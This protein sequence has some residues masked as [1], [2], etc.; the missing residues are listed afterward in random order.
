[1]RVESRNRI[2]GNILVMMTVVSLAFVTFGQLQQG[3]GVVPI[4]ISGSAATATSAAQ[5]EPGLTNQ[6]RFDATNAATAARISATNNAGVT[7][8]LNAETSDLATVAETANAVNAA[9][10][11]SAG[12]FTGTGTPGLVGIWAPN[13]GGTVYWSPPSSN[14]PIGSAIFLGADHVLSIGKLQSTNIAGVF[15]NEVNTSGSVTASG[16]SSTSSTWGTVTMPVN[17]NG[18]SYFTNTASYTIWYAVKGTSITVGTTTV[19]TYPTNQALV[20]SAT[21]QAFFPMSPND[22]AMVTNASI[23]GAQSKKIP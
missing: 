4:S 12:N 16:F 6:W 9:N 2:L 10:S 23:T 19:S 15:T 8:N 17:V 11:Y 7:V 22:V 5:V 20:I 21:T 18:V 13:S 1:M 3:N 14:A